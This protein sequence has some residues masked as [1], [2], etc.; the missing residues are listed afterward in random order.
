MLF[1][2][3]GDALPEPGPTIAGYMYQTWPK[4]RLLVWARPG[5]SGTGEPGDWLE[6]GQPATEPPDENTDV[7]AH[8]APS[9]QKRAM[10][11]R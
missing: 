6:N 11:C 2:S 9:S 1:R 10:L 4:A 5:R 3:A 8:V 7:L